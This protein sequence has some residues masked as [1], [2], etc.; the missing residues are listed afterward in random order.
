[1]KYRDQYKDIIDFKGVDYQIIGMSN[2]SEPGAVGDVEIL[3]KCQDRFGG[4]KDIMDW[5]LEEYRESK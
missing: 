4:I 5:E 3:Y 1:M 2:A